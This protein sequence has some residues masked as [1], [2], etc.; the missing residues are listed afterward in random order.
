MN[1]T[2]AARLAGIS[3]ATLN[4]HIRSG[5]VT[6]GT[7]ATGK[8][9][10][11][12]DEL[13][14]VYGPLAPDADAPEAAPDAAPAD[15]LDD[16]GELEGPNA[17]SDANTDDQDAAP[18]PGSARAVLD[19][20]AAHVAQAEDRF[21]RDGDEALGFHTQDPTPVSPV[22]EG[23]GPPRSEIDSVKRPFVFPP[24]LSPKEP[25]PASPDKQGPDRARAGEDALSA[26]LVA[27]HEEIAALRSELRQSSQVL[28]QYP[29][30]S[31]RS[32]RPGTDLL[33]AILFC[34]AVVSIV[35]IAGIWLAYGW[36][37]LLEIADVSF[38]RLIKMLWIWP[39]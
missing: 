25:T 35:F 19:A 32:N 26:K 12:M 4:R 13:A 39:L 31:T 1:L 17:D 11:E 2:D 36:P 15:E 28:H 18:S 16:A 37:Q 21:Q 23:A 7:D 14:R 22:T 27:L 6:K 5:R 38:T 20:A 8:P 10:V 33:I 3:R 9:F 24:P 30:A 34:W 29:T